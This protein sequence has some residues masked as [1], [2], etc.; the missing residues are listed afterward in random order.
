MERDSASLKTTAGGS[1]I[2]S[3]ALILLV[4][5]L[6]GLDYLINGLNWFHK[7]I[8]PYPSIS[9]F[10]AFH[11]PP[12]I[13]GALIE[14]GVLFP[15][16]KAIELITGLALLSDVFVPLALVLAMTV[17]VPVFIVDTLN[18]HPHLR[19]ILMGTG[20][21]TMNLFL[22][23]AYFGHYRSMLTVRGHAILD[24]RSGV[25]RDYMASALRPLMPALG[26]LSALLGLSMVIW[27]GVMIVQYTIHPLPISAI[28]A[29][30]PR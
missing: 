29:L 27:L 4:R 23:G 2:W 21:L 24:P 26:V 15:L 25:D 5:Y 7:I 8:T 6:L 10:I 20:A 19:A 11:P 17:T 28:H 3:R 22:L 1:V 14:N 30:Q 16:A 13:V 18:G 12:D 9:D